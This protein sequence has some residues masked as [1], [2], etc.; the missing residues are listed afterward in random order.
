MNAPLFL[1]QVL[2]KTIEILSRAWNIAAGRRRTAVEVDQADS[3]IG[4][5]VSH[6]DV[7]PFQITVAHPNPVHRAQQGTEELP[8]AKLLRVDQLLPAL[9]QGDGVFDKLHEDEGTAQKPEATLFETEKG[10]RNGYAADK[11]LPADQPGAHRPGTAEG[12]ADTVGQATAVVTL[13]H[14]PDAGNLHQSDMGAAA[15]LEDAGMIEG[16]VRI[17]EQ[18]R[19]GRFSGG[20]ALPQ[21]QKAMALFPNE[22]GIAAEGLPRLPVPVANG[23]GELTRRKAGCRR[24]RLQRS[25]LLFLQ[26]SREKRDGFLHVLFPGEGE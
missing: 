22:S 4:G 26:Q 10:F 2:E 6:Q 9:S 5:L 8:E 25:A 13:Q 12:V 19:Q 18:I 23:T 1:V 16:L 24:N 3:R 11:V 15:G 21:D 7:V 17:G 14:I 20:D